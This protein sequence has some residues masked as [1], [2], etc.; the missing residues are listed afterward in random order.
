MLSR[1]K[2]FFCKARPSYLRGSTERALSEDTVSQVLARNARDMPEQ[3]AVVSDFQDL[4]L[5]FRE[6]FDISR[7]AAANL[8]DLGLQPGTKLGIYSLNNIEWLICQY[9]CALA[10]LHM[11]TI[12]P[13]YKPRELIH[14]LSL[15][16]VDTLL[17]TDNIL[18]GRILDSV[19]AIMQ[20]QNVQLRANDELGK[21]KITLRTD[22]VQ[23]SGASIPEDRLTAAHSKPAGSGSGQNAFCDK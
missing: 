7:R 1:L 16:E 21:P 4:Q 12:N 9:A 23:A 20:R 13:A 10:D 18:P 8:K 5:T 2:R 22:R 11:V 15:A 19:D 6:L 14:G 17:V 3:L